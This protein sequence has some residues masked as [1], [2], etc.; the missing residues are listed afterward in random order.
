MVTKRQPSSVRVLSA[1][2]DDDPIFS[3]P[4][5]WRGEF[6]DR[7]FVAGKMPQW[8]TSNYGLTNWWA[9]GIDGSGVVVVVVDTGIDPTHADSGDLA[10]KIVGRVDATGQGVVDG[11]GHG[12]HCAGIVG[13]R[14][15]GKGVVGVAP[16]AK[17]VSA[18]GLTNAGTGSAN[19]LSKAYDLGCAEAE[20]HASI[21]IVTSNSWGG[22]TPI[23]KVDKT[24]EKWHEK[25]V[26]CLAAAGNDGTPNSVSYPAAGPLAA[27]IGAHDEAGALASFSS[28]GPEVDL[29][30]PGVQI[31]STVP[32]GDYQRYSGT[33]MATPWAA[34]AVALRLHA[35]WRALGAVQTKTYAQLGTLWD[36]C[37]D[38]LGDA[39][40]DP[41]WGRGVLNIDRW[42]TYG[43]VPPPAPGPGPTHTYEIR[44]EGLWA[45]VDSRTPPT[46]KLLK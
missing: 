3:L 43:L 23:P 8:W 13:A 9:K 27:A 5:H 12:T 4:P 38:D 19:T 1:D 42:L 29:V 46:V 6:L 35:E 16:G 17:I 36:A 21:A 31:L 22:Y 15:D 34:G 33:S 20:R 39:G 18:K 37:C 41:S 44:A 28:Q 40:R 14:Y 32:G 24:I 7:E 30:S 45:W 11:N 10:E 25:G 2:Q 26:L